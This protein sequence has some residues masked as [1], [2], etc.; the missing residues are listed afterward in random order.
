MVNTQIGKLPVELDL[1]SCRYQ[2][3]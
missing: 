1:V 3:S 2:V